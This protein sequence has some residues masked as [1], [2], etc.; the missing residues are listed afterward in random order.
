MRV[1]AGVAIRKGNLFVTEVSSTK[2]LS[3]GR[4]RGAAASVDTG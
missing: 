1:F 2:A 4:V 3:K